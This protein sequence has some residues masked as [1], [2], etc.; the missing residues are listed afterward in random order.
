MS[1][2]SSQSYER[3][4]KERERKRT[5]EFDDVTKRY[6]DVTAV[7]DVSFSIEEKEFLTLLGPSG[8]GKSTLLHMVAGFTQPTAGEI[9]IE[10]EPVSAKPPYERNIGM[11]FQSMALFPHKTV[12]GNIAFPLKM[13]RYD[14]DSIDRRVDEMLDLIRLPGIEDR[15]ISELSGGQQQRIAIARALAFEPSL[16][17]LDEPLSSLD[18]KLREEMRHEITRIHEES[19]VT[20]IHVTHN[21]EEALTMADRIAVINDGEIE[22]LAD[23]TTLYERPATAFVADFIGN[24]N[25]FSGRVT[26]EEGCVEAAEN[27]FEMNAVLDGY[28]PDDGVRFGIRHEQIRIG[29]EGF[30]TDNEYEATVTDRVYRG[31]LIEYSVRLD[32]S[33]AVLN[34]SQLNE[35]YTK[36]YEVGDDVRIGWNSDNVLVYPE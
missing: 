14:P 21:Q 30:G 5:V 13:R 20:T 25:M 4:E 26:D 8:A 1:E 10:G 9:Y 3:S 29:D 27:P 31:D 15:Q 18:K 23:T 33:D 35:K 6:G 32:R 17:L 36:V 19:D 11:V 16:L 24:T 2:I 12:R 7:S 22:Q 34:V 28:R